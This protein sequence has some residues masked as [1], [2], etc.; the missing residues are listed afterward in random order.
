MG[1][2]FLTA[3]LAGL[4]LGGCTTTSFAPPEIEMR[5]KVTGVEAGTCIVTTESGK[6]GEDVAG[7]MVLIDNVLASYHCAARDVANGRQA[8][9]IPSFLALIAAGVG[10]PVYGLSR[11][12]VLAAG[13][14]SAVMGRANGYF[15]P[16]DKAN[17]LFAA[18][19][20]VLCIQNASVGYDYLDRNAGGSGDQVALAGATTLQ[21]DVLDVVQKKIASIEA[22][23]AVPG[24]PADRSTA[25]RTQ[26]KEM[27]DLETALARQMGVMALDAGVK[28]NPALAYFKLVKGGLYQVDRVIAKRLSDSGTFDAA[29]IAAELEK[30]NGQ[31][32][33]AQDDKKGFIDGS[34]TPPSGLLSTQEALIN[35]E[36]DE[37]DARIQK[38]VVLA[39]TR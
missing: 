38:C 6:V 3:G 5:H 4:A 11:N 12:E 39:K 8:F 37:L 27:K 25:L 36:L 35:V 15:A 21:K 23:L 19:D 31:Q 30:Y 34:K 9:E 24:L 20:G 32:R 22:E 33:E 2:R 26:L 14:Y 29:G 17:V 10:G 16:K 1:G 28:I 13:A 7:A 18:I